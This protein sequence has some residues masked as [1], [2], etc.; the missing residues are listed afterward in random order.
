[1]DYL[2]GLALV[3]KRG[4]KSFDYFYN[5]HKNLYTNLKEKDNFD[6]SLLI[7]CLYSFACLVQNISHDSSMPPFGNISDS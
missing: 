3:I 5:L 4:E 7:T 1:M 2:K 6:N